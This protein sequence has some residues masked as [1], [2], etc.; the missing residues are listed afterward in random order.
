MYPDELGVKARPVVR[1]ISGRF[2]PCEDF[3]NR[4]PPTHFAFSVAMLRDALPIYRPPHVVSD[5]TNFIVCIR[6]SGQ[7]RRF[8]GPRTNHNRASIHQVANLSHYWK[9]EPVNVV[10]ND[11]GFVTRAAR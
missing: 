10:W 9:R 4:F 3:G 6:I 5:R 11:E 2:C 1:E 7:T 8:S